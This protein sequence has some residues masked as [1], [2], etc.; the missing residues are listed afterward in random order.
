MHNPPVPWGPISPL[1][2]VKHSTSTP[3]A[4]ISTSRLPAVWAASSTSSAPWRWAIS[5]TLATSST[6]P[7]RLEAWVQTTSRVLGRIKFSK[8]L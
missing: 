6:L 5:E 8:S 7:V 2:P 1:C 4:S 3:M